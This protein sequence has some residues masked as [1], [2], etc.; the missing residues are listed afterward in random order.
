MKKLITAAGAMLALAISPGIVAA[1]ADQTGSAYD[2]SFAGID[3][4]VLPLSAWRGKV[5]LVVNTASFCGFTD[6][7]AALQQLWTTYEAKGLVVVGVP[8]NDFG[9]QEPKVEAEIQ[10]FCTG[11]F[12]VTFPL[13]AKSQVSGN[14]AH[15][16]YAWA[17]KALPPGNEPKWNFHKYLI[18]R[19]GRLIASFSTTTKPDAKPVISAIEAALGAAP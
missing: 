8:S 11:A 2:Y 7:Y 13:A 3:G 1:R 6:Q 15:P 16:F 9:E 5:V 19:D 17:A 10:T 12:G 14:D 18:G 4:V